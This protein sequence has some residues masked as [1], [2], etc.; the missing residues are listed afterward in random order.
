MFSLKD[1]PTLLYTPF[2]K[3]K[4]E[5][6]SLNRN[7]KSRQNHKAYKIIKYCETYEQRYNEV[8]VPSPLERIAYSLSFACVKILR[9]PILSVMVLGAFSWQQRFLTSLATRSL[10]KLTILIY[11]TFSKWAFRSGL[12]KFRYCISAYLNVVS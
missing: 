7:I 6:S 3:S 2:I 10:K 1:G 4:L 11:F 8:E 9:V 12:D 5:Q